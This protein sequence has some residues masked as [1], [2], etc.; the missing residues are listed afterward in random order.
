[1]DSNALFTLLL[2]TFIFW[3]DFSS[4]VLPSHDCRIQNATCMKQCS[5]VQQN[6]PERPIC[7]LTSLTFASAAKNPVSEID[8]SNGNINLNSLPSSLGGVVLEK[9][10]KLNVSGNHLAQSGT[11]G[12][13]GTMTLPAFVSQFQSLTVLDLANVAHSGLVI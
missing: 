9:V 1:M 4:G 6:D 8:L 7:V 11:S 3:I 13:S 2:A 5:S 12:T 10:K